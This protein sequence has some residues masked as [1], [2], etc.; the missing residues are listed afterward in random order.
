MRRQISSPGPTVTPIAS[1]S[2]T[3]DSPAAAMA[4]LTT[5]PT[6]SMCA[7]LASPGTTPPHSAW[8]ASCLAMASPRM[9]PSLRTTAA[10]VSS[11]DVSMP[12]TMNGCDRSGRPESA[13]ALILSPETPLASVSIA[14][15]MPRSSLGAVLG[16][17]SGAADMRRATRA[18]REMG[19]SRIVRAIASGLAQVR[20]MP[21]W[22]NIRRT[23][24]PAARISARKQRRRG[25]PLHDGGRRSSSNL[26]G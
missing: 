12:R 1:T 7:S 23:P 10:A 18:M 11:Q 15:G 2:A 20:P 19:A 26:D 14:L 16:I 22:R 21:P 13:S 9:T 4:S 5:R 8:I 24:R 25:V 3:L 6:A 17:R